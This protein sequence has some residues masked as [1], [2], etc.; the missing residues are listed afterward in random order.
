MQSSCINIYSIEYLDADRRSSE[1]VRNLRKESKNRIKLLKRNIRDLQS[2]IY[3]ERLRYLQHEE[4]VLKI[5]DPKVELGPKKFSFK[6]V[7]E[8]YI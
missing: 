4:L 3:T 5:A 2:E 1:I 8:L 7:E 6:V